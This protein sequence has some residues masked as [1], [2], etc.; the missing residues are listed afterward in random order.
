MNIKARSR[1]HARYLAVADCLPRNSQGILERPPEQRELTSQTD[2][3]PWRLAIS[4][5][6]GFV[7]SALPIEMLAPVRYRESVAMSFASALD[8]LSDKRLKFGIE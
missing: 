8:R 3:I 4:I 6:S 7:R 1:I 2:H 5:K